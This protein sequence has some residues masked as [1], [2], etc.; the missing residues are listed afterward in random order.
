MIQL[1][2]LA[3]FLF[4]ALI[5]FVIDYSAVAI[6]AQ[7][8]RSPAIRNVEGWAVKVDPILLQPRNSNLLDSSLAALGNHLQRAKFILHN[9]K[10]KSLQAIPIWL[11]FENKLEVLQYH[12]SARWLAQNGH[13]PA[14]AKHVHVPRA[15]QL[16][17]P[18][19]WAKHPYAIMHELAHAYHDQILGYD[20]AEVIAAFRQAKNSGSYDSVLAHDHRQAKHYA[21]SNVQEYFAESTE[22]YLGVNDFYPFVRA[23]LKQ[24]DP[25][26]F[27]LMEKVWGKIE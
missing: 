23:E 10:I 26:M 4:V 15:S 24:H 12:P 27:S 17:D 7:N 9:D 18:V 21:L 6:S 19:Q 16:L 11:D 1:P 25:R 22:A 3:K 2:E 8:F 5:A 20:D 13:N 14:L